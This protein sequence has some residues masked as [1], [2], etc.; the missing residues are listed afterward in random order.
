[1]AHDAGADE[2]IDY[3][4]Q[5]FAAETRR[6]TGGAGVHV[7]YDSVGQST[8][9]KSLDCLVPRGT[10]ALFGQSSGRVPPFDPQILNR[11]GSLFLTRPTVAHYIAT[12]AELE[13]RAKDLFDWVTAG[14]LHVRVGAEFP[15]ARAADAHQG[16]RGAADDGQGIAL[17]PITARRET[18]RRA[19]GYVRIALPRRLV[20]G[21]NSRRK[22]PCLFTSRSRRVAR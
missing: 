22:A 19:P 17:A 7:V 16:A 11:K 15:L 9:D 10:M 12:R 13:Q 4:T 1:M 8:F 2:M 3:T 18:I 14:Q 5:D 21:R 20:A 6:I